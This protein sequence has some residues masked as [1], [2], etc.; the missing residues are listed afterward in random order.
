MRSATGNTCPTCRPQAQASK[1]HLRDDGERRSRVAVVDA[2]ELGR[3][4]GAT[5]TP[6]IPQHV[7]VIDIAVSLALAGLTLEPDHKSSTSDRLAEAS[8]ILTGV[9]W[10]RLAS[11]DPTNRFWASA[12]PASAACVIRGRPSR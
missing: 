2:F 3:G 8:V 12:L 5:R 11:T 7:I 4:H 6:P 10:E 1:R 9:H